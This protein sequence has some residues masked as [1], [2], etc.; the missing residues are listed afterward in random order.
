M[1]EIRNNVAK[2]RNVYMVENGPNLRYWIVGEDEFQY[3]QRKNHNNLWLQKFL[4]HCKS[5]YLK[6]NIVIVPLYYC[7]SFTPKIFTQNPDKFCILNEKFN[8][9]HRD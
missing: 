1:D 8:L 7:V 9:Q 5:L 3:Y 6:D 2:K 4:L